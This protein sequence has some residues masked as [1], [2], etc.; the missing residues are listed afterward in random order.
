MY[1]I[2]MELKDTMSINRKRE[3]LYKNKNNQHLKDYFKYCLDSMMQYGIKNMPELK[4]PDGDTLNWSKIIS[5][6]NRMLKD[7]KN[8]KEFLSEVESTYNKKE[9]IILTNI[10]KKDPDCGVSVALVN[11]TWKDLIF[12]GVKLCKAVS[13]SDKNLS[14]IKY[15]AIAQTKADGARCLLFKKSWLS[16]L[17]NYEVSLCSSSG[18][19]FYHLEHLGSAVCEF[20]NN[21]VLDGELVVL[22]E[23]GKIM[24]RKTGN[25]ILNKSIKNTITK[26][27][28][29]RVRFIVWDMI[30][31]DEYDNGISKVPYKTRLEALRKHCNESIRL[32]D[33]TIVQ[34]KNE[35]H[36]EFVRQLELGEEGII[37]KNSN[38][39]WEGKRIK[40]HV[41]YKADLQC[42]LEVIGWAYGGKGTKYENMLGSLTCASSDRKI[43]V[44]VGSGLSDSY[45]KEFMDFPD[46]EKTGFFVEIEYN[47]L[48]QDETDK[49]RFSLFLPRLVDFRLDKTEADSYDT[50]CKLVDV[51][52]C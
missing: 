28:A 45:R 48:I 42:T 13:Y 4:L 19:P 51:S 17:Q 41:K 18:K 8:K 3:I 24:P 5:S 26:E 35:A 1:D 33:T 38:S 29:E 21:I 6:A 11:D 27:E 7:K 2:L 46:S 12:Q 52:K 43:I 34:N 47:A 25:G 31:V 49:S 14:Y 40:E 23:N 44:N 32:I 50:V 39:F 16:G 9:Y 22:D 10:F 37:L 36:K 20:P 15:P 30:S